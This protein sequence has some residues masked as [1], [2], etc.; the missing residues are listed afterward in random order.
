MNDTDH[1]LDLAINYALFGSYG[2]ELTK[3]RKRTGANVMFPLLCNSYCALACISCRLSRKLTMTRS[4]EH[5]MAS[6]L[7]QWS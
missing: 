4:I 7:D 5:L 1:I 3:E 2:E 6:L